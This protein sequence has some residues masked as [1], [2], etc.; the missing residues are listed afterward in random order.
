MRLETTPCLY[1]R[2]GRKLVLV[3]MWISTAVRQQQIPMEGSG[4]IFPRG[5]YWTYLAIRL[6]T[7]KGRFLVRIWL[8]SILLLLISWFYVRF[9]VVSSSTAKWSKFQ[10]LAP[11]ISAVVAVLMTF[12]F[13]FYCRPRVGQTNWRGRMRDLIRPVPKM[14]PIDP[15]TVGRNWAIDD[16]YGPTRIPPPMVDPLSPIETN[17]ITD[18]S[19]PGNPS[20]APSGYGRLAEV[21]GEPVGSNIPGGRVYPFAP[22]YPLNN[23]HA[24][25]TPS[26]PTSNTSLLSRIPKNIRLPWKPRPTPIRVIQPSARF[27]VDHR[28]ESLQ[29]MS[30]AGTQDSITS[31]GPE[32][33][34][35]SSDVHE[36]DDNQENVGMENQTDDQ[37]SD[38]GTSLISRSQRER[39]SLQTSQAH[40]SS[41]DSHV[42][43]IAPSNSSSS[44]RDSRQGSSSFVRY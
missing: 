34:R 13:V 7:S 40:T 17:R 4:L 42:K 41:I 11:V 28:Q 9:K 18:I 26:P 23:P 36:H 32:R 25:Q 3:V 30:S 43:I 15:P 14:R 2:T 16:V 19:V 1:F 39:M 35:G 5:A 10:I 6:L 20:A 33:Q 27:R 44:P 12:V 24:S 8:H 22:R 29:D 37:G 21:T 31:W 38:E